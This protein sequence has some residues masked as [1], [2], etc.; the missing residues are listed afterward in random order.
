MSVLSDMSNDDLEQ[1]YYAASRQFPS[2]FDG[3]RAVAEAAVAADRAARSEALTTT[4]VQPVPDHCDRITWR[5]SYFN[6]PITTPA[7]LAVPEGWKLVPVEPTEEMLESARLA[8]ESEG[9]TT[10]TWLRNCVYRAMFAAAH[11]PETPT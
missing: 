10:T 3:L 7:A 5:G 4:Y 1:I 2:S 9:L 11:N 6:L 8:T